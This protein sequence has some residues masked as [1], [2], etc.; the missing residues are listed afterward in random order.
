MGTVCLFRILNVDSQ[1]RI[2]LAPETF[3]ST[4]AL[5]QPQAAEIRVNRN[6]GQWPKD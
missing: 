6:G 5:A 4:G 2:P 1:P 3:D